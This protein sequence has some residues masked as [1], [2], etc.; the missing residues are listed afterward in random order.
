MADVLLAD[1]LLRDAPEGEDGFYET[2]VGHR[3]LSVQIGHGFIP[4]LLVNADSATDPLA[5]GRSSYE[6]FIQ[7]Q[8][9]K[10]LIEEVG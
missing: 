4:M 10:R 2:S 7:S 3:F 8:P 1:R 5:T 6:V 9:E